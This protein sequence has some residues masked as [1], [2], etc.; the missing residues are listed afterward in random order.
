MKKSKQEQS[1]FNQ[2]LAKV[3]DERNK[4]LSSISE[5]LHFLL[6]LVLEELPEKA[7]ILCVGA[8][9]G[10]EIL[11]LAKSFPNFT[12]LAVEPSLPMLEVCRQR[13]LAAGYTNRCE[14]LHGLVQDLPT[15]EGFDATLA[16]LV[17]HFIKRDERLPFYKSMST[18]LRPGG[19]FVN[20]EI[21]FALESPEFPAM[22]KNWRSIQERMGASPESLESLAQQLREMLTILSPTEVESSIK[23]AGI[24]LP[25]QFFQSFM[26]HAWYGI[27]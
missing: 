19:Y 4:P 20:A 7:K 3:Y 5:N 8:G 6:K 13:V 14:F 22:L 21:S 10:A 12:F 9:T 11:S 24:A 15:G 18:R 17:G 25:I 26:I 2:E 1:F 16:I 27:K 23:E